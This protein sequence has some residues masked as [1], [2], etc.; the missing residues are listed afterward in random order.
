MTGLCYAW[1]KLAEQDIT[2]LAV[3]IYKN[4]QSTSSYGAVSVGVTIG[5][6]AGVI[7]R[8]TDNMATGYE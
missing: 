6:T 8:K 5:L 4:Q 3:P 1:L 2:L 7:V